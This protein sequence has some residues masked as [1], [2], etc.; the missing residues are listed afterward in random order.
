MKKIDDTK[1]DQDFMYEKIT[2]NEREIAF[3]KKRY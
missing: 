1:L 3:I 2:K